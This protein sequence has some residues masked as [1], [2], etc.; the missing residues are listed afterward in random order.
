[1]TPEI[2]LAVSSNCPLCPAVK[3]TLAEMATKN[4]I[5]SYELVNIQTEP[6]QLEKYQ[7]RSVPWLKI[8]PFILYGV[9]TQS[10]IKHWYQTASSPEGV[11][12][13]ISSMLND[14]NLNNVAE[15]LKHSPQLIHEFIPLIAADDSSINV[16]LGISAILEEL[17]GDKTIQVL[18]TDLPDLL[19]HA[20]ARVRGDAAHFIS[21]LHD[22]SLIQM[23]EPLHHDPDPGVREIAEDAIEYLNSL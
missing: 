3:Q 8:G 1:M 17:A 7:I 10:E 16:R 23:L 4:E 13:Y 22:K 21:L 9:H 18:K 5:A 6:S 2:I 15:M 14:G 11:S 19:K 20:N 12:D